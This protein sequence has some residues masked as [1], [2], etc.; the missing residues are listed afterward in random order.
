MADGA[1]RRCSGGALRSGAAGRRWARLPQPRH[2][3]GVRPSAAAPPVA[4]S[5]PPAP[6][7]RRRRPPRAHCPSGVGRQLA[8][9]LAGRSP[10]TE[11]PS[12]VPQR[13]G[14]AAAVRR[15][16][17][18]GA[19]GSQRYR[20]RGD[21]EADDSHGRRVLY[22]PAGREHYAL[23]AHLARRLHEQGGGLIVELGVR[24]GM[25]SVALGQHRRN[26]LFSFDLH[27]PAERLARALRRH[28]GPAGAGPEDALAAAGNVH[29]VRA[30]VLAPEHSRW[31]AVLAGAAL[32]LLDTAHVPE[33]HPFE[34]DVALYLDHA[35]FSGTLVLDDIHVNPQMERFWGWVRARHGSAAADATK[36]GHASGT[37]LVNFCGNAT[38]T[39]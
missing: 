9:L 13:W 36:I 15:G 24:E 10:T 30:N 29:F 38:V 11:S 27:D 4:L 35:G 21:N 34:Y 14:G 31:R 23:L 19:A 33:K 17:Q 18:E 20:P 32:V 28:G 16:G 3:G 6:P 22:R 12:G 2:S 25:S 39:A 37:G 26:A 8:L 1:A 7:R 5:R